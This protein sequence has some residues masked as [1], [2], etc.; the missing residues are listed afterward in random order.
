[1][2]WTQ[3]ITWCQKVQKRW[4]FEAY[5][6]YRIWPTPSPPPDDFFVFGGI[7]S[8]WDDPQSTSYKLSHTGS[9]DGQRYNT[10]FISKFMYKNIL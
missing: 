4:N 10:H 7:S 1:L 5:Y 8:F 9:L 6:M 3:I 2:G